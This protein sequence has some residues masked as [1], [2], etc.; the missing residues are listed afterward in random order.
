M[1]RSFTRWATPA[2]D[3]SRR[4]F[5]QQVLTAAALLPAVAAAAP[6]LGKPQAFSLQTLKER[7]KTLAKF[8]W[9]PPR[10]AAGKYFN[11]LDFDH[12][13]AIRFRQD[14]ALWLPDGEFTAQFH[15]PGFYFKDAVQ[16]FE[17]VEGEAREI[18]Y[19]P[20]MYEFGANDV[21][22]GAS[23]EVRGF[24]GFRLHYRLNSAYRDELASFLGGSYFRGLGRDMIYGVSARGLAI[25]TA[26]PKGE[27]FPV[28]Q[29]FWIERP[30]DAR[31]VRVHALLNSQSCTGVYT[32]DIQ[33]GIATVMDVSMTLYLRKDIGNV[34]IAPLTSMYLFGANDRVGVDDYRAAVHDSDGLHLWTGQGE[35]LWRPLVNGKRL[36]FSAFQDRNP[37]GF[38]LFQRARRMDDYGDP[39]SAYERRP[40]V[41]VEPVGDWG[42]GAVVLI[43]IPSDLESND[44][45]VAFWRPEAPLRAGSEFQSRY[46]VHWCREHPVAPRLATVAATRVGRGSSPQHR[47][48]AIDFKGPALASAS[49]PAPEFEGAKAG[50]SAAQ[51][52]PLPDESGVRLGFEFKPRSREPEELRCRLMAGGQAVTEWWT[53]QWTE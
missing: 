36:R 32:F 16:I 3:L 41:W 49:A 37:R 29:E 48:F 11:G 31:Q 53:Y 25:G 2:P 18:L 4:H 5:L 45:I 28:F 22:A 21:P 47:F 24:A 12:Y 17:V 10:A 42:P 15:H 19:S 20:A 27:E 26:S 6:A 13:H 38:G 46:R 30:A 34:G 14:Q 8:P 52:T 23:A 33:P 51:L 35:W 44:N 1:P 50:I 43:E 39:V 9:A 7:A 40:S